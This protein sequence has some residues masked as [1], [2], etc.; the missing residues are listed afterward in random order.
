[1][2]VEDIG[3]GPPVLAI[4]GLGGGAYFFRSIA[5]R[6]RHDYRIISV[7]L[8]TTPGCSM[9]AWVDELGTIVDERIGDTVVILG[10]S[11]GTIIGLEAWRAWPEKLRGL[12]FVG[13][14]PRVA[15]HIHERLSERVRALRDEP[16][17]AGWGKR[18]SP[19]VFAAST[20]QGRPEVVGAF[21]RLFETQSV[22]AYVRCC[23]IL[24]GAN[25]EDIVPTVTVP[26][27][28]ITGA[29]D[30]YAPP[31]AVREFV[32]R[33][34]APCPVEII[35]GAAHLPFLEQPDEF[36]E[37]VNRVLSLTRRAEL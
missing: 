25:A 32:G 31:S 23:E 30:Q 19:G 20:F 14:V 34:P 4:H 27:A 18:V 22:D 37:A 26:C 24:I 11:M 15:P 16:D 29:E 10:H 21:E 1:M 2:D 35:D 33:L 6:L 9:A 5:E 8:P 13:G 36:A 28:A 7:D 17:L 3:S 12:V